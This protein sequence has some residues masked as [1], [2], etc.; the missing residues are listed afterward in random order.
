MDSPKSGDPSAAVL[1]VPSPMLEKLTVKSW[2]YIESD[3]IVTRLSS[4]AGRCLRVSSL[5]SR[6][7]RCR[8]GHKPTRTVIFRLLCVYD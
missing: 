3:K 1:V 5:C 4:F 8:F 7:L 6:T 2:H